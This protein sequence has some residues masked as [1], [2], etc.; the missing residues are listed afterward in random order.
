M[1]AL[2]HFPPRI[3]L[4]QDQ[5]EFDGD[6]QLWVEGFVRVMMPW[7]ATENIHAITKPT[8]SIVRKS[9]EERNAIHL[10]SYSLRIRIFFEQSIA[11]TDVAEEM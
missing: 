5:H 2:Q 4:E 11:R 1:H 7:I 9:K 6:H 8:A 3:H 10:G